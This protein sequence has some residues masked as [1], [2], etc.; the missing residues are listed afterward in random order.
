[1]RR[2][3]TLFRPRIHHYSSLPR[4]ITL[5]ALADAHHLGKLR[6]SG[7]VTPFAAQGA[8][9]VGM[10]TSQPI[11]AP[12]LQSFS[13]LH[14]DIHR[15]QSGVQPRET[16][17]CGAGKISSAWM[18]QSLKGT[19][20]SIQRADHWVICSSIS[21][22]AVGVIVHRMHHLSPVRWWR[23][24]DAVHQ[25][26]TRNSIC[27]VACHVDLGAQHLTVRG[28]RRSSY[29]LE[30]SGSPRPNGHRHGD[31]VRCG[32]LPA[33]LTNLLRLVVDA[34]AFLITPRPTRLVENG[35]DTPALQLPLEA[36]PLD[37]ARQ[38]VDILTSSFTGFVS[39]ETP[40]ARTYAAC[41]CSRRS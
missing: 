36:E 12:F 35:S 14:F 7:R 17:V 33:V 27:R 34:V 1:M 21:P 24:N 19:V 9:M 40:V 41:S 6:A 22:L 8:Q 29:P 18:N 3:A 13:S 28:I 23:V 15:Q 31:G 37:I 5:L 16:H 11:T 38:S 25:R 10:R 4:S 26:V 2:W 32:N 39:S 20:T 30:R